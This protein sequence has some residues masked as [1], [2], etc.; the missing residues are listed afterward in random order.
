MSKRIVFLLLLS[1]IL[2][3]GCKNSDNLSNKASTSSKATTQTTS[4]VE[5]K[6]TT[7]DNI[8][9]GKDTKT[10]VESPPLTSN[11]KTKETDNI[12][13]VLDSIDSVLD[14]GDEA[15]ELNLD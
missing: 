7:T 13:S 4:T 2:L 10:N 9:E 11:E 12:K 1:T 5:K 3:A 14:S 6:A 8:V 15:E